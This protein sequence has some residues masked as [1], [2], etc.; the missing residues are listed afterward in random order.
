[1]SRVAQRFACARTRRR[2]R[3]RGLVQPSLPAAVAMGLT[4]PE[5]AAR[6]LDE[7]ARDIRDHGEHAGLWPLLIGAWKRKEAR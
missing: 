5:A 2:A 1:M 7:L 4:T 3:R 6:W